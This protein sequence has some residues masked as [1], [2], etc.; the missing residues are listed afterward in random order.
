MKFGLLKRFPLGLLHIEFRLE[1]ERPKK[2]IFGC[3]A[4]IIY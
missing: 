2:N 4:M 1:A 3:R